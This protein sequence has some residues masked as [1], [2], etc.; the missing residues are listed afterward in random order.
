MHSRCT[1]SEGPRSEPWPGGLSWPTCSPGLR[2]K[3]PAPALLSVSPF[4]SRLRSIPKQT[5]TERLPLARHSRFT[6]SQM[7]SCPPAVR[8]LASRLASSVRSA[9]APP[10]T[11]GPAFFP[12][13][14]AL[15]APA[16]RT[17]RGLL[18]SAAWR[19]RKPGWRT[20]RS[21]DGD[22]VCVFTDLCTLR[23]CPQTV[24]NCPSS[25]SR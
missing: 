7:D 19:R 24:T 8:S 15:G 21:P 10:Q 22:C 6:G 4:A 11:S 13:A 20:R 23:D 1:S 16:S 12:W 2:S 18:Y 5:F 17:H 25:L 3:C 14:R 9:R